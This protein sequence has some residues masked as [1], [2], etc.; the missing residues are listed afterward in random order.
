VHLL[1]QVSES[2]YQEFKQCVILQIFITLNVRKNTYNATQL[3]QLIH[4]T[5]KHSHGYTYKAISNLFLDNT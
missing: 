3:F 1:N 5:K 4:G 2:F